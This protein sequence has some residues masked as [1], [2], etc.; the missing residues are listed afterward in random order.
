LAA[1]AHIEIYSALGQKILTT[2]ASTIDVSDLS[3]GLYCVKIHQ[4][5]Q[6]TS[7]KWLKE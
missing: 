6:T 4:N 7:L 3:R 2:T 1:D 5:G